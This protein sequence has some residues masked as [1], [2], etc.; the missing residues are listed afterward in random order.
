AGGSPR[1]SRLPLGLARAGGWRDTALSLGV[2]EVKDL[3]TGRVYSGG[4]TSLDNLLADYPV[5]LL[6]PLPAAEE[7]V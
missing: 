7:A 2:N 6:A 3:F 4:E 5:A 1:R